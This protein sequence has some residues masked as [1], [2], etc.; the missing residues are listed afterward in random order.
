MHSLP[1]GFSKQR[2]PG[3]QIVVRHVDDPRHCTP[4]AVLVHLDPDGHLVVMQLAPLPA[5]AKPARHSAP[6]G[7]SVQLAPGLHTTVIQLEEPKHCTPFAVGVHLLPDGHLVVKQD[8]PAVAPKP[9]S[10]HSAPLGFSAQLAPGLQRTLKQ[11]DDPMHC[12]PVA[13]ST[14]RLVTGQVVVKQ[15]VP[16]PPPTA[17]YDSMHSL[18]LG[19]S[20]HEDPGLHTTVL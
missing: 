14:H 16:P 17:P 12:T 9:P 3:E 20:T 1:L 2:I 11:V 6:L 8:A 4:F 13:V 18:P 5:D 10:K 7:F 15:L 19:F